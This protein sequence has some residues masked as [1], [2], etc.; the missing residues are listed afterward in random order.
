MLNSSLPIPLCGPYSKVR[1]DTVDNFPLREPSSKLLGELVTGKLNAEI[2][3]L[4]V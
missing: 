2:G 1:A 3:I 4:R